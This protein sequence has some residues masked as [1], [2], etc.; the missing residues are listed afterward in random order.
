ML[1]RDARALLDLHHALD[2]EVDD[3]WGAWSG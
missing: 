1:L 2:P 3:P